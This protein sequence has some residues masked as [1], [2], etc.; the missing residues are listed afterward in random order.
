MSPMKIILLWSLL[1]FSVIAFGQDNFVSG[2]Y[3]DQNNIKIEGFIEDVNSSNNPESITFKTAL[4]DKSIVIPIA[5]IKEFKVSS[6]FK[7]IKYIVKYDYAQVMNKSEINIYGKE[8]D[9]RKKTVLAKVI[10]EGETSFL[11]VVIS[12]ISFFY[13]KNSNDENPRL[14]KYRKYNDNNT[15][16]ENNE[17]RKQLYDEL[18]SDKLVMANFLNLKYREADLAPIFK[19]VN[20]DNNTLVE[21]NISVEK[22]KNKFNFKIIAGLSSAYATY[23]FKGVTMKPV[24]ITYTNPMFG[25]EI[26]T[27][28]GTDSKRSEFFGRV[29]Y[30]NLKSKA[31]YYAEQNAFIIDYTTAYTMNSDISTLNLSGGYR[32]AIFQKGK[33]K[34]TIDGSI[35]Y[36]SVL[37]GDAVIDYLVTYTGP[38]PSPPVEKTTPFDTF[39]STLFFNV[40]CGYVF[41][42]KYGVTLEYSPQ[43]NYLD[44]YVILEGGYSNFNLIFTYTF[45]N[46]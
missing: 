7:H 1:F 40:G 5:N 31:N 22:Y 18:K 20:V 21:Q 3:I 36:S 27:I 24:D 45:K 26:S 10:V 33:N 23:D 46:K 41:D 13:I 2:Y 8:L 11:K 35:G 17:F 32:Y 29:F 30:Q 16:R 12:D 43:K 42:N 9:L 25:F 28:F 38:N 6:N 37:S 4:D 19:D 34:V 44:Q 14:L 39:A 15:I